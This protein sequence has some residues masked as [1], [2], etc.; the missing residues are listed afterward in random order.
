MKAKPDEVKAHTKLCTVCK[1]PFYAKVYGS[2]R[3]K[4]TCSISCRNSLNAKK[5]DKKSRN[6]GEE[7]CLTCGK[8]FTLHVTHQV[9]CSEACL[10]K[11][12][13]KRHA[14]YYK[15]R[16]RV[17]VSK[18]RIGLNIRDETLQ[19]PSKDAKWLWDGLGRWSV[20]YPDIT[21]CLECNTSVYKH[22]G[23]G[24]CAKCYDKLRPRDDE[25]VKEWR[26]K[27]YERAKAKGY[28]PSRTV[29]KEWISK[30]KNKEIPITPKI[31]NLLTNLEKL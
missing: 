4:I 26:K 6:F 7:K 29:A 19:T 9:Y 22:L 10:S 30:A 5:Q 17:K 24:I 16:D 8:Y 12:H 27:S 2:T 18:N 14:D 25:E 13:Y 28:K 31:E 3:L 21:E 15:E 1:K 20:K 11:A 23:N